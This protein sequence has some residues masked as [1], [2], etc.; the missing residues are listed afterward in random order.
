MIR[1]HTLLVVVFFG[2]C[3]LAGDKL[4]VVNFLSTPPTDIDRAIVAHFEKLYSLLNVDATDHQH[5]YTLPKGIRGFGPTAPAYIEGHCIAG[6]VS[7]SYVITVEGAGTS[8]FVLKSTDPLLD[9][10]AK[11]RMSR[12]VFR[13]AELDAR[14]VASI[15]ATQFAFQCPTTTGVPTSVLGRAGT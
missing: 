5:S 11:Q 10:G 4:V 13:A 3:V 15:A 2:A 12:R 6:T 14:P 7:L 9:D 1:R 8:L